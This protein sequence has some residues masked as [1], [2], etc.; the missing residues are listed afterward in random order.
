MGKAKRRKARQKRW[1]KN[2]C[3]EQQRRR[4]IDGFRNY[5]INKG[6]LNK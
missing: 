1:L 3:K 5:F 2:R 6:I 4:F